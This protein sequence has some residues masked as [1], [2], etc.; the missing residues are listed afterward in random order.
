MA[1]CLSDDRLLKRIVLASTTNL[2]N[3]MP[4]GKY[5]MGE[6]YKFQK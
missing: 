3:K 1:K 5:I 6:F 2:P 4:P